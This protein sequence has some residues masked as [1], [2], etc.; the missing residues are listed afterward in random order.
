MQT[1]RSITGTSR[2]HN[3]DIC[4]FSHVPISYHLYILHNNYTLPIL[5]YFGKQM[6]STF[7]MHFLKSLVSIY[8]IITDS[9]NIYPVALFLKEMQL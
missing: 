6:T 8:Y 1:A 7:I 5:Q 2:L 9:M 3:H 4:V